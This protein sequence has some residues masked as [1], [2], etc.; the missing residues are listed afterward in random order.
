MPTRTLRM[1]LM[2]DNTSDG[3]SPNPDLS[4]KSPMF[5]PY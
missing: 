3:R 2:G 4:V 5:L 1:L